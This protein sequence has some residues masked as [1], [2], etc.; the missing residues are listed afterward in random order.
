[1]DGNFIDA[2][3][4]FWRFDPVRDSW[5]TGDMAVIQKDFLPADLQPLL[6]ENRIGGCIAVQASQSEEET[7]FL[8]QLASENDFIRGVVG[9][10][11][12]TAEN[13]HSRLAYYRQYD[14][15]KGFRHILQS[16]EDRAF[17]LRPDF[18]KGIA[19]LQAFGFTY[20]ILIYPDQLQYAEEMAGKF[21]DATFI[22]D[23]IAKPAIKN[24][25]IDEWK[26]GMKKLAAHKNVFCKVS[27]MV[28]EA[29]WTGWQAE[30]FSIYLD[31]VVELFGINRLLYGSDWPVCLVAASYAE[32]IDIVKKYFSKFSDAEQALFF[33]INAYNIYN[34]TYTHEPSVS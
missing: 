19:A 18:L 24:K 7:D 1:M 33:G 12:L 22:L 26:I 25:K 14:I 6:L 11:D 30:D 9:W 16:E 13:I 20:D 8:I 27:G 29:D 17:M 2:H 28:T 34:L 10:T 32:T 21:P 15:L 31:A 3:Q 5:I 23:H 4:H